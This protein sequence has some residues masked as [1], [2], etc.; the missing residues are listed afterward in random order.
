MTGQ[1]RRVFP[2]HHAP[3]ALVAVV[4]FPT[5]RGENVHVKN[6]SLGGLCFATEID[7]SGESVFNLSLSF[8]GEA[9]PALDITVSAKIAWHIHD[10]ATSLHTAGAKFVEMTD[11][12]EQA[13][14]DF[15]GS[16][17]SSAE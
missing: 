13:L 6:I 16:L 12:D 8:A 15:M 9:G 10:E 3:S 17:E 7:I 1:E 2:R 14:G 4:S 5:R 11:A